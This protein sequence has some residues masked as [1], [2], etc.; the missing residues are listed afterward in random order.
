MVALA[1]QRLS[2]IPSRYLLTLCWREE[3][4]EKQGRREK[5]HPTKCRV[6][7]NGKERQ[8]PFFHE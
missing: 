3:R 7:R 8:K 2:E 6:P 4:S 1:K 5:L